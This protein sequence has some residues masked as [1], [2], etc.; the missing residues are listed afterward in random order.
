MREELVIGALAMAVRNRD[1]GIGDVVFHSDRGS[2]YTGRAFRD[3]CLM[4]GLSGSPG[5]P[6]R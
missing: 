5:A 4:D 6:H 3:A 2:Q 1:P